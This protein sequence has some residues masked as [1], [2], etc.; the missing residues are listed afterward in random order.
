M[1]STEYKVTEFELV[2]PG[3][4]SQDHDFLRKE[5]LEDLVTPEQARELTWMLKDTDK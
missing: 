4:D 1:Q 3:F 2:I 5:Q